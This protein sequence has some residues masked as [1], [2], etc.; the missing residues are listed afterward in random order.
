MLGDS[1][2]MEE[3]QA[4]N[5]QRELESKNSVLEAAEQQQVPVKKLPAG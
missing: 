4:D 1:I 3:D 2:I 5:L